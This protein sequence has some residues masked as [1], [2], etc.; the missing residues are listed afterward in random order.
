MCQQPRSC[1][2]HG[3]NQYVRGGGNAG[4]W[5][6]TLL[7]ARARSGLQRL[8]PMGIWVVGD[9]WGCSISHHL[10]PHVPTLYTPPGSVARLC[11]T[12]RPAAKA[13]GFPVRGGSFGAA[14]NGAAPC[15]WPHC[16]ASSQNT[17][18]S[19][20]TSLAAPLG[21]AVTARALFLGRL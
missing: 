11:P 10:S 16:T 20:P 12:V 2:L 5:R 7:A 14:G 6:S 9:G 13:C 18:S 3:E 1:Y 15:P 8:L 4:T 21:T 17:P 19:Q